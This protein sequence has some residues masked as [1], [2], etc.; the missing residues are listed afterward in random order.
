MVSLAL[1]LYISSMNKNTFTSSVPIF[2]P[3][4][5]FSC[6]IVVVR[7][8]NIVFNRRGER[9]HSFFVV[10]HKGKVISLLLFNASWRCFTDAPLSGII[11]TSF[12]CLLPCTVYDK[13]FIMILCSSV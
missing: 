8:S 12:H 9:G 7:I 2:V 11:K 4:I 5:P 10:G 13:K 1:S 6:L 3:F